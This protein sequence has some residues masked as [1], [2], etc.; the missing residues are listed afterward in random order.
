MIIEGLKENDLENLVL[1][2]ISIDEYESKIDDTAIVIGFY[3]SYKDP[4]KDLNKFIQKTNIDI[5][6]TDVSPAPTEDGYYIVFV[7]VERDND[8][9]D[10]IISLANN[11]NNLADIS[12]WKFKTF[13]I[14]KVFELT[15][16][17]LEK[18]VPISLHDDDNDNIKDDE[19]NIEESL[20]NFFKESILDDLYIENNQLLMIKNGKKL[21]L[22]YIDYGN[23][24]E[25]RYNN[26]LIN[27]AIVYDFASYSET[28]LINYFIGNNWLVEKYNNIF[29]LKKD[30]DNNELLVRLI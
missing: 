12:D 23:S 5:I 19:N 2:I 8:L 16:E 1:N 18:Y 28:S 13:G 26:N 10:N 20:F 27:E 3:I 25:L 14:E 7:E 6:D 17:N 24:E 11:I 9:Y 29:S 4:A 22:E 21:F 15:K 30:S